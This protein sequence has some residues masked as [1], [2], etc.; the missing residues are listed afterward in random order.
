MFQFQ[1]WWLPEGETHLVEYLR[2]RPQYQPV[3]RQVSLQYVR[4]FRNAVDI[5]AH[6]GL[7]SRELS[8]RFGHVHAFEPV[9]EYAEC[10]L[11][12]VPRGNVTLHRYALGR[13]AGHV[14]VEFAKPGSSGETFVREAPAGLP[15]RTLDSFELDEVDFIKIDVEGF[16]LFVCEG[17]LETLIHCRP[18]VVIE[19]KA[20]GS[21]Y[22]GVPQYAARDYL[23]ELG[24][25]VLHQ[26]NDD[27]VLGW[28]G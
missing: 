24:A 2:M 20:H 28:E 3:H 17:A 22:F 18:V 12:N 27:W 11:R 6:I 9:A 21:S 1:D 8:E 14:A 13:E 7:W 25:S 19:Q 15:M 23:V 5:G 26:V 4:Q 16:E 10:F